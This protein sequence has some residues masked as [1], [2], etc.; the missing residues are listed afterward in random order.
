MDADTVAVLDAIG[1]RLRRLR[2]SRQLT[3]AEVAALSGL[4]VSALSRIET[5]RRQPTLDALIPLARAFGVSL[6][7]IIAAPETGDPRVNLEPQRLSTG[8]VAVPLTRYPGRVQ[9]FKHVLG[10]REPVLASHPGHA[11][12]HVLAGHLRLILSGEEHRLEPGEQVEF[13]SSLPHWFGPADQRAVEILHLF[14]PDGERPVTR[15]LPDDRP[16]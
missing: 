4:S 13:D 6:D 14:V 8:G 10:P 1:P 11:W 7:R 16:R 5:G 15:V 2:S 9:A 12:I 3:L